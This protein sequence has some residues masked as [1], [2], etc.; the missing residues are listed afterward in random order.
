MYGYGP[1]ITSGVVRIVSVAAGFLTT[2]EV[3]RATIPPN[4]GAILEFNEGGMTATNAS[5]ATYSYL[6]TSS[7]PSQIAG[8]VVTDTDPTTDLLVGFETRDY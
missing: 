2:A 8:I 6:T 4:Q 7:I 3:Y 1:T 5:G